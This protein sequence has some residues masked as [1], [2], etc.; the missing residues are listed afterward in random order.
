[1][2]P[3]AQSSKVRKF[4]ERP[5]AADHA[6]QGLGNLPTPLPL[7]PAKRQRRHREKR[8][9]ERAVVQQY[10]PAVD[11]S[12]FLF[13]NTGQ[14]NRLECAARLS[15]EQGERLT[16]LR[17]ELESLK[18]RMHALRV[19]LRGLLGKCSPAVKY[20]TRHH[21]QETGFIEWLDAD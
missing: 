1:M 16:A 15:A 21:L 11:E 12:H 4:G 10:R 20:M 18:V 19:S 14:R 17:A 5:N 13:E 7:T 8:E 3:S 2:V 9:A 6:Q